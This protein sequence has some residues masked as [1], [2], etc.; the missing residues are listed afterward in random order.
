MKEGLLSII[1]IIVVII[2]LFFLGIF[3]FKYF[4]KYNMEKPNQ[5]EDLNQK[6]Y[7]SLNTLSPNQNNQKESNNK[8]NENASINKPQQISGASGGGSSAQTQTNNPTQIPEDIDPRDIYGSPCG[9]Y[10]RA[11][12]I[13]AGTCPAGTCVNEQDS[14]Y[15]K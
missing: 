6:E 13:C 3:I 1:I 4:Q 14:C 2:S 7:N 11:Y 10:F 15:C 12:A 5:S 9:S 8:D